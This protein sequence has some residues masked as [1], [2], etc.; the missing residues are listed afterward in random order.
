MLETVRGRVAA[1]IASGATLEQVVAAK[2]TAEWDEKYGNPAT[3]FLDRAY[4]S[5]KE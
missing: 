2:P 5:L 3:Y 4:K 1:L